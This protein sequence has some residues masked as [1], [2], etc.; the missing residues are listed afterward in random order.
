MLVS[1]NSAGTGSANGPN[2][3]ASSE[4]ILSPN[5]RY[6]AFLSNT[7]D[8]V[9]G[10]VAG[11]SNIYAN[12]LYLRDL[13]LGV[14]RLVTVDQS[15]TAGGNAD[16]M[17]QPFEFSGGSA[18][19]FFDSADSNLYPGDRNGLVT[20]QYISVSDVFA[21]STAG[22]AGISGQVFNDL[23]GNG[24]DNGEPGLAYWTV[25]LDSNK[26]GKLDPGE[27]SPRSPMYFG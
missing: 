7:P 6:V 14:T 27:E 24:N 22:F 8:L 21:V 16:Q 11:S 10:F 4:P 17:G 26:N 23:N 25:F 18:T 9:P 5:G 15:G 2:Y 20:N 3:S 12:D 1:I 19:L 13:Q